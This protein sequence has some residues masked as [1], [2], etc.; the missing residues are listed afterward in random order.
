MSHNLRLMRG[1]RENPQAQNHRHARTC[2]GSAISRTLTRRKASQKKNVENVWHPRRIKLEQHRAA[3]LFS[4][5]LWWFWRDFRGAR[6]PLATCWFS[7]HFVLSLVLHVFALVC[8]CSFRRDPA[9]NMKASCGNEVCA[10]AAWDARSI[11]RDQLK[12]APCW[13]VPFEQHPSLPTWQSPVPR[14]SNSR[15]VHRCQLDDIRFP[16]H[17]M[18]CNPRLPAAALSL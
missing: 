2:C 5:V 16:D 4:H 15:S 18:P 17:R 14:A 13:N 3:P 1:T 12:D 6:R 9:P 10:V 7:S 11:H 8:F